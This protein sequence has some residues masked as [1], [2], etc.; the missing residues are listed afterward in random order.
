MLIVVKYFVHN[1]L[2]AILDHLLLIDFHVIWKN[3][4]FH[5][6]VNFEYIVV[7]YFVIYLPH[8]TLTL[9]ARQS[10]FQYLELH[11]TYYQSNEEGQRSLPC[12]IH[13]NFLRKYKQI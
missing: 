5:D 11:Y 6:L 1:I 10:S 7:A 13:L 2:E 9:E 4:N 3:Y 12:K 8:L